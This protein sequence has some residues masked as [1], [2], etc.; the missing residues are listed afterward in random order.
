MLLRDFV[1]QLNSQ[2][3]QLSATLNVAD[4]VRF[5]TLAAEALHIAGE[6]LRL[7]STRFTLIPFLATA[8]SPGYPHDLY[9]ELWRIMFAI[10]PSCRINPSATV[11]KFGMQ[12]D[13]TTKLPERFLRAPFSQCLVCCSN[14]HSHNLHVHSRLNGYLYDVDGVHTIE[15]V[16]LCCSITVVWTADQL[17][18]TFYRPSFYTRDG[19]R[20]YYTNEMGRDQDYLHVHCHYYMTCRLAYM[21]R[22]IQML[23]HVSH[24]NLVNWFNQIFVDDSDVATFTPRQG[25]TPSLSE[26]VC[27]DGLILHSLINHADRRGSFLAVTSSGTDSI[28]FDS[29]IEL[30]LN[31][32]DIEGS[33]YRDHY[34]SSCVRLTPGGVDPDTGE[35]I[36]KSPHLSNC[37]KSLDLLDSPH[38]KALAQRSW[39]TS[40]IGIAPTTFQSWVGAVKHNPALSQRVKIARLATT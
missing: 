24:F 5:A 3:P 39:Q 27:R 32:L 25:F 28:R 16:I 17:C 19:L 12:E 23:A 7:T 29:A 37:R 14:G 21:F 2:S 33:R 8:L 31:Q 10:L 6:S 13:L 20:H 15:T 36:Y 34:C 11:R 38:L 22:I 4:F 40:T 35:V 9:S 26:E 18:G 1:A 30:H